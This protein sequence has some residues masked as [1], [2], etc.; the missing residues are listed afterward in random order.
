MEEYRRW[1]DNIKMDLKEIGV[2]LM[3]IGMVPGS[4]WAVTG[5]RRLSVATCEVCLTTAVTFPLARK[6]VKHEQGCPHFSVS[7]LSA[8]YPTT[9]NIPS[10]YPKTNYLP[11]LYP[12]TNY[13]STSTRQPII[14]Q[15]STRKLI[16]YQH[17]PDN[18][19]STNSLPDNQLSTQIDYVPE[20]KQLFTPTIIYLN[21]QFTLNTS[22]VDKQNLLVPI[23]Y[24]NELPTRTNLLP[25][26]TIHPKQKSS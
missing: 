3:R 8:V 14:Y 20:N 26:P 7:Q 16:I 22:L 4:L 6:Y 17:L 11:T 25:E 15:H 24:P 13:I 23:T 12:K 18:Q 19:L 21:Q 1:E 10:L 2:D 9:N 5:T